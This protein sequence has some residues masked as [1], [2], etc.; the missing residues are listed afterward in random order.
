M[1]TQGVIWFLAFLYYYKKAEIR[2]KI[3]AILLS[4]ALNIVSIYILKTLIGR[5]RPSMSSLDSL[6][7]PLSFD[8]AYHS[9]PSSHAAAIFITAAALS[10]FFPKF[11]SVFFPLG[12]LFALSRFMTGHHFVSDILIGSII[13][14]GITELMFKKT[15]SLAEKFSFSNFIQ[16]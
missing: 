2:E 5:A 4:F 7:S 10:N 15:P 1:K 11:K 6:F 16:K 8:N 12:L 9:F 13:G 14:I 3:A